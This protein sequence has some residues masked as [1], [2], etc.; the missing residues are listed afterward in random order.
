MDIILMV[1]GQV[2]RPCHVHH[3]K[4]S[5]SQI[6]WPSPNCKGG[7]ETQ[8]PGV[9]G[10]RQEWDWRAKSQPLPYSWGQD[11]EGWLP[12]EV[13]DISLL[14]P[15]DCPDSGMSNSYEALAF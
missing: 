11:T 14:T 10:M 9:S 3:V 1:Y 6:P 8:S 7:W 12:G 4:V 2:C 5:R 13:V 15:P